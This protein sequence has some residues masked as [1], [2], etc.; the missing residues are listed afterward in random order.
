MARPSRHAAAKRVA[1]VARRKPGG[2]HRWNGLCYLPKHGDLTNW[3]VF[4]PAAPDVIDVAEF[5]RDDP[6][7][8]AALALH[9]LG[10][11]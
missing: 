8:L 3:A 4:E 10:L 6:D 11:E 9:N 5:D 7:L 1:P 2:G